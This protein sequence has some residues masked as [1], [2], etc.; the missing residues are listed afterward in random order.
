MQL[1]FLRAVLI[2][3]AASV[4]TAAAAQDSDTA[5]SIPVT[6]DAAPA[7]APSQAINLGLE[8]AGGY[9]DNVYA[10]RNREQDDFYLL[11]KPFAKAELAS[12][13]SSATLRAE[14]EI[15]RYAELTSENYEDWLLA[16]DGRTR[17][18]RNLSLLGGAEWRWDHE[19]RASPEAVS[20]VEPTRYRRGYGYLGLLGQSGALSGRLA[21]TLTRY[22]FS[23]VQGATGTINNHDR[24]RLQGE[25]GARVGYQIG[26]G[27]QLFA[28]GAY[29][30]RDYDERFDD[31][32]Y[33][34]NSHG[35]SLAVGVSGKLGDR[36]TG[37]VF[38]GWLKQ[39]YRDPRLKDVD[40][41]DIGATLDWKGTNG[42]GG[43]FRLDRS[44]EETTLPGASGYVVT[45]G[46]IGVRHDA[47]AR[48]SAGAGLTGTQY[49]YI[50]N[51]RT[52]FVIG[53]DV[54]AKYWVDRSIYLGVDY[55]HGERSSNAAGYDYAQN[56]FQFS[57]GAQL[58][59][60]FT[61]D[62]MPLVLAE[63]AP[64]GA[65]V[66]TLFAHE[67]VVTG[68]DGPRGANGTNTAD[69]GND[70]SSGV[71]VAGYG[72]VAGS[73]YLGL[74]AEGS[75][76]GP[77]WTHSGDRTFSIDKRSAF[78][79][80]AR[81]GW[82]TARHDLIYARFGWS[83][84]D[85]RTAYS[86]KDNAY[87]ETRNRSG[88]GVGGGIE[89]PV[90]KRGFLRTEYLV[91]SYRSYDVPTTRGAFDNFSSDESQF[92]V[93]GGMR[94]GKAAS[95]EADLPPVNFGGAYVGIQVGHGALIT[96]NQGPRSE[97][98]FILDVSRAGHGGLAG[99]YAGYGAILGRAYLGLEGEAD[100][101][102]IDWNI[103]RDPNGRIYSAQHKWSFGG[104]VRGGVRIGSSALLY[105][106]AGLVRTRF[107][108]PYQTSGTAVYSRETRPGA[109]FGGG[110]E[111]GLGG[112]AR[113]RADYTVTQYRAYDIEYG[114]NSDRFDHSETLF[115]LG[116]S[117]RL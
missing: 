23:N 2:A 31:F 88:F 87:S 26:S 19:G 105:G 59:P 83:S 61:A 24:D 96:S 5:P 46:R 65:Y 77:S 109:R 75:V 69:F 20:G 93:G 37:E 101:S 14:G 84:A 34:R 115:R 40:T 11:A 43:S 81:A 100:V 102:A 112:R 72:V 76:D 28:Q 4:A 85:F 82:A 80:A 97:G 30:W 52:E 66:G 68:L 45:S 25:I 108:V 111:V 103:E 51:P 44:I 90:G 94:F 58:R 8:L 1:K 29:D 53:A 7:P 104:S 21:G 114:R 36:F 71:V 98:D 74:E 27:P 54:W 89:L 48:L 116:L 9:D 6:S 92:R 35:V 22:E 117:W 91:T 49:D 32:S 18:T 70:G 73:L 56:R 86:V 10:T 42:L 99:L 12:A 55:S 79:I 106:R 13:A 57:V 63:Q 17:L 50:G 47:N 39:D 16:A 110:L 41:F 33:A 38:A 60:G 3:S 78:G 64:A 15:G 62:A 95:E 67:A 107:D 113:L